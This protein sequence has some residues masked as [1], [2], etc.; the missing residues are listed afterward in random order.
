MLLKIYR[1]CE[2]KSK[3]EEDRTDG[4]D[5]NAEPKD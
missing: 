3:Q 5:I 2:P 1:N 4:G